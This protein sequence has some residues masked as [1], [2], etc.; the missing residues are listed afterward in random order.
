MELSTPYE[1]LLAA[2]SSMVGTGV[3]EHPRDIDQAREFVTSNRAA[4]D[5]ARATLRE[6]CSVPL[7][8]ELSFLRE[9]AQD[10]DILRNL[11]RAFGLEFQIASREREYGR[12]AGIGVVMLDL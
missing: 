8:Y 6:K 12:A 2:S 9:H 4:L 3:L 5:L 1:R 7:K 10:Y 11:L